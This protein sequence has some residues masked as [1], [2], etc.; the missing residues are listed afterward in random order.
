MEAYTDVEVINLSGDG[1]TCAKP[2]NYPFDYGQTGIFFDG[3]PMVCGGKGNSDWKTDCYKYNVQVRRAKGVS[4]SGIPKSTS[5]R[6]GVTQVDLES[7]S[8]QL[9]NHLGYIKLYF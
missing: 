7:T 8:N 9:G 6:L 1:K 5:A 4:G 3:Y 2:S